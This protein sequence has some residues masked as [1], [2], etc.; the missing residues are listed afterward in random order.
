ML[1]AGLAEVGRS[2]DDI[3]LIGGTRATF[4]GPDSVADVEQAMADIPDQIERGYSTFCMKPSQ[5]TDD[6][7][8][9]SDVCHRMMELVAD[10]DVSNCPGV[11]S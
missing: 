1:A 3:E 4:D 6:L 11:A 8:E 5:Y 10:L 2:I 9:V 7:G